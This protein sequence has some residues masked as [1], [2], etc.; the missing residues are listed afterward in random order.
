MP[1]GLRPC[2]VT[3]DQPPADLAPAERS[4][5]VLRRSRQSPEPAPLL[6]ASPADL[7]AEGH[8][9]LARG[10][11]LL[12]QAAARRATAA[13]LDL[14]SAMG[15]AQP[16]PA[17]YTTSKLGPAVP[18]KTRRWMLRHVPSMPGAS[19]LGRDWVIRRE[20]FD[21]WV[22][23]RP[24]SRMRLANSTGMRPGLA[25]DEALADEALRAAGYLPSIKRF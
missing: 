1:P 7:E 17:F 9:L 15:G 22:A 2:E 6:R 4:Q 12:A 10:Y 25:A 16:P 3:A 21:D 13:R 20:D 5:P 24:Q 8:A 23:S 11:N 18:G 14:A 19:K